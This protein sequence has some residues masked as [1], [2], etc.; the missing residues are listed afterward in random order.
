[1]NG[2]GFFSLATANRALGL[3]LGLVVFASPASATKSWRDVEA[4]TLFLRFASGEYGW[5]KTKWVAPTLDTDVDLT[6]TGPIVRAV[7]KQRFYNPS[8]QWAEAIYLFPLPATAAVDQMRLRIGQRIIEGQIREREQAKK[9]YRAARR[10]GKRASLVEQE[11]PNLFT[12]SVANIPPGEQIVVEI[13]YQHRVERQGNQ[14]SLRYPMTITPRYIPGQMFT[15][16]G[17]DASGQ[18]MSEPS[19]TGL[20]ADTAVVPDASRITPPWGMQT[21]NHNPTRIRV[22]LNPGF[23]IGQVDSLSHRVRTD[24]PTPSQYVINLD[25][26]PDTGSDIA[27]SDFVLHWRPEDSAVPQAA[28]FIEHL[29]GSADSETYGL[30]QVTPPTLVA[31]K[32]RLPRDVVFVID[33]SGSMGGESI[34]Q[35]KQSLLWALD[36]LQPQDRFN[37]IEFNSVT[38][39]L[40]DDVQ[41][42]VPGVLSRARTFVERLQARGGT[43]MLGAARAALCKTCDNADRVRQIIFIT[44]GAIGNE[45][46]LFTSI[47]DNIGVTRL[48]TVGIGSAPNGYFMRRA[49]EFGR[50]TFTWIANASD[51]ERSMAELYQKIEAPVLT[52][53]ELTLPSQG[54]NLEILPNPIP[55]LYAGEPLVAVMRIESASVPSH[56]NVQG[57]AGQVIWQERIDWNGQADGAAQ[58]QTGIHLLWARKKIE[59]LTDLRNHSRV[60]TKRDDLRD[61]VVQLALRHHLVSP[62]TSLVAVDVTPVRPTKHPLKTHN[63]PNNP[64]KGT[65][66]GLPQTATPAAQQILSG[67][68]LLTL[69]VLMF[70]RSRPVSK[71]RYLACLSH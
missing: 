47:R 19:G 62:F 27:N 21:E 60:Q 8:D 29:P 1:M 44:D 51:V 16:V 10:E 55:D 58:T 18:P 64:P 48:F 24:A 52:D 2:R 6:V 33:T 54:A 12:T 20:V 57:R 32:M 26:S 41:L 67:L 49:A 15:E 53:L 25:S 56:V 43:E 30:L 70:A 59:Q 11:R 5:G 34:R 13:E 38:T 28:F 63:I 36:R 9:I 68:L 23:A 3:W 50:G 46:Q 69:A 40:F 31:S 37:I 66:F 22:T 71:R 7:V 42:A 61:Q 14:Y 65:R 17:D 4:G 35:A 45:A 39:L